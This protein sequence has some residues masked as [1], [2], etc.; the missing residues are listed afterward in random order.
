MSDD[1]DGE[2]HGGMDDDEGTW[3]EF[4]DE[5]GHGLSDGGDACDDESDVSAEDLAEDWHDEQDPL[6]EADEPEDAIECPVPESVGN[7]PNTYATL[8]R[9]CDKRLD[10]QKI[11]YVSR[12]GTAASA[13]LFLVKQYQMDV[14]LY[15][16]RD[17]T[18]I[19]GDRDPVSDIEI[20]F[21]TRAFYSY[22]GDVTRERL[23]SCSQHAMAVHSKT[24][25]LQNLINAMLYEQRHKNSFVDLPS[26]KKKTRKK[27]KRAVPFGRL[28]N[29]RTSCVTGDKSASMADIQAEV[30][31]HFDFLLPPSIC[32][33]FFDADDI[34]GR[35]LID[36]KLSSKID[37]MEVS[38]NELD[39]DQSG[40]LLN[41]KNITED[42]M[43]LF[44]PARRYE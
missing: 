25:R 15:R 32:R 34:C 5:A 2:R 13:K 27:L 19:I 39:A 3:G 30:V 23:K 6:S 37:G 7:E 21:E 11:K 16:D 20:F 12:D 36:A 38:A 18:N 42:D 29:L 9:D 22:D 1:S 35:L 24:L 10:D 40:G 33:R 8:V 17:C 26:K 4:F 41:K 44:E 31:Q 28:E 14:E 43:D